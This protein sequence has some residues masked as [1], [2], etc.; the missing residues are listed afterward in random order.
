MSKKTLIAATLLAIAL[1]LATTVSAQGK[2]TQQAAKSEGIMKPIHISV[3]SRE[4]HRVD[5]RLFGQFLERPSWGETG[6]EIAT[7]DKSAIANFSSSSVPVA[8]SAATT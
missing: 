7:D 8:N 3:E 6:P 5:A 2:N 1:G 4:L